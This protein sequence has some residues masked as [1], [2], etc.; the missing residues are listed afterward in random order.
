LFWT[1]E[2]R[3]PIGALFLLGERNADLRISLQAV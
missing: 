1:C 2:L 3:S